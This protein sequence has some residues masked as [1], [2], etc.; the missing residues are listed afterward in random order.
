[1]SKSGSR[2]GRRS[3]WFKI[4]CL[5]QEQQQQQAAA[6]AAHGTSKTTPPPPSM[7]GHNSYPHGMCSRPPCTKEEL[8][9]LGF[10]DYKYPSASPSVSSPDSH[11]SDSSVEVGDRR[12]SMLRHSLPQRESVPPPPF[13][14]ELF[15]PLSF[16]GLQ[17]PPPGFRPTG[18]PSHL[19]FPGY[20]P[21]LYAQ[22]HGLLKPVLDAQSMMNASHQQH[23][24]AA[25]AAA[26]ASA[27]NNSRYAP[28]HNNNK[29]DEQNKRFYLDVVL[30]KQQGSS[31]EQDQSE[32]K[33]SCKD[34]NEEQEID[35]EEE[36]EVS[37]TPPRSPPPTFSNHSTTCHSV[38]R[39][40]QSSTP[41]S[42]PP[43]VTSM[44]HLHQDIPIDLSMKTGSSCSSDDARTM[45]PGGRSDTSSLL[46]DHDKKS[47]RSS[48][49][50]SEADDDSEF[51]RHDAK[52][53]KLTTTPL[54]L[55][56][57]V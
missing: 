38:A 2:Y 27:N 41:P 20:H 29:N 54:D 14:K 6:V 12:N 7:H 39:L 49:A 24:A 17:M 56:T 43:N 11:N 51:M 42:M 37:M 5:F 19:M 15:L 9:L 52:R 34:E 32:S 57:K 18:I 35:N 13:N 25:A 3:N 26:A 55:T 22:H 8:M 44:S 50:I 45:S 36:L 23:M 40:T 46:D 16:P 31:T 4:H 33:H 10:E 1:M 48:P 47:R 53:I 30:K 28:N 21:A